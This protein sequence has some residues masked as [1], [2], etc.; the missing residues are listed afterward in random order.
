MA[1]FNPAALKTAERSLV[2]MCPKAYRWVHEMREIAETFEQDGGFEEGESSFR[3][4]AEVYE[5]V[6][7]GT[8]LGGETVEERKLGNTAEDVARI[9]SEGTKRRKEKSD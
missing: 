9:V 4:I 1:E 5:L 8:E 7:N 3:S 2:A 6:A